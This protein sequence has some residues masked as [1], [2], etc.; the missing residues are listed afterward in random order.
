MVVISVEVDGALQEAIS[1]QAIVF[2]GGQ[3]EGN[4]SLS[5][6]NFADGGRGDDVLTASNVASSFN[7]FEFHQV[8]N[9]GW[10][11][12]TDK[13]WLSED[14]YNGLYGGIGFG[15]DT[16]EGNIH[17]D[18]LIGGYGLDTIHGGDGNDRIYGDGY[19]RSFTGVIGT[20]AI[21]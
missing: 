11:D 16:L 12:Y 1:S 13:G 15:D 2:Y 4:D 21:I 8:Y 3:D 6:V 17:N 18:I 20:E 7:R 10:R 19:A 5:Y 9:N 14:N